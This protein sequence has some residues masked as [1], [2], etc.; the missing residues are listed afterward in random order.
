MKNI[1]DERFSDT[2]FNNI[3]YMSSSLSSKKYLAVDTPSFNTT[4][5]INLN[6]IKNSSKKIEN[7]IF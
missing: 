1:K 6:E 3:V 4:N 5:E 7:T 2:N